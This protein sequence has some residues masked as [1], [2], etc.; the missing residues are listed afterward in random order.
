MN[1]LSLVIP[2]KNESESLPLVLKELDKYNL[3][4]RIILHKDDKTTINAIKENFKEIIFQKNKGYGDALITGITNLDTKYFCIFNADGSFKPTDIKE[5]LLKLEKEGLDIVF[6]SRYEDN[7]GSDDDT[8]VTY[9]GNYVFTKLGNIFFKLN[10]SDILYT[11]LIGKTEKVRQLNLNEK[12]F[13]FCVELP[14]KAK[15]FGLKILSMPAYER[16]RIA[17][18]KKVSAFKDGLSILICM[19]NLFFGK[20]NK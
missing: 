16:K 8:L 14:I 19:I 11:F 7:A 1:D 13:N 18:Q 15:R 5:L 3:K 20:K 4:R 10:I 2:A 6:A 12:N 9:I 17:G